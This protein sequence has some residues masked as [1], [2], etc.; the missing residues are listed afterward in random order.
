MKALMSRFPALRQVIRY[1][2]VGV[3]NNLLGYLIYLL[4]TFLWL[5]P[6]VA[7]SVLYP[8]GATTA[9]FGH[10]KFSFVYQGKNTH[11]LLRYIV[12]HLISY[13][14]NFFMLY[15]LWEKLKFPHQAVQAVAIFVCAGILFLMFKYF[16]FPHSENEK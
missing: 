11:A 7:I 3:L 14:V 12:A 8:V 6:K 1:G 2:V 5:D 13:G 4:V 15:I 10:S 16:V 9:Y